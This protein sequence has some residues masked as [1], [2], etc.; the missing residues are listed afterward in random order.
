MIGQ[1]K[2]HGKVLDNVELTIRY[3]GQTIDMAIGWYLHAH[4]MGS[5]VHLFPDYLRDAN[6]KLG[7]YEFLMQNCELE[8]VLF[9]QTINF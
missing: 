2:L 4:V 1:G 9:H 8:L 7:G 6:L 3:D 5:F